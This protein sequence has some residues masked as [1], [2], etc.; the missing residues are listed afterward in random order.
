MI[1]LIDFYIFEGILSCQEIKDLL[2]IVK[3]FPIGEIIWDGRL[4]IDSIEK[5]SGDMPSGGINLDA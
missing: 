2:I 4:Y 5:V 3:Q 1:N